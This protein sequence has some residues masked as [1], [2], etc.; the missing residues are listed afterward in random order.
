MAINIFKWLV[1]KNADD[2]II[3]SCKNLDEAYTDYYLR[4]LAF[5]VCVNIYAKALTL[6]E[7]ETLRNGKRIKDKEYYMLNIEPNINQ[8]KSEFLQDIVKS[9]FAKNEA[10]C[11]STKHRDGH[12]MLVCADS[13]QNSPRYPAKMN[14][15]SGVTVGE[16]Q[17]DKTF[18]ENEVLHF[19]LNNSNID[20]LIN[21][22]SASYNKLIQAAE[23]AYSWSNGK[24][25]VAEIEQTDSAKTASGKSYAEVFM[26][27]AEKQIAPWMKSANGVLPQFKGWKYVFPNVGESKVSSSDIKALYDDVF[28][29]TAMAFGIPAPLV[30]GKVADSKDSF[31]RWLTTGIDPLCRQIEEEIIRKRYGFDL[32]QNGTTIHI[33]TNTIKHF[34]LFENANNIEKLISSGTHSIND[35]LEAMGSSAINEDYANIHW[36]TKNIDTAE[37]VSRSIDNA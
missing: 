21:M 34:D 28:E 25:L 29:Y 7:F 16:V 14:E 13:W 2:P 10:L 9:L 1:G 18:R 33:N 23:T 17:Y 36:M 15:Y 3:E 11:I 8:N 35:V 6:C 26:E 19:R 22:L 32:W 24:H 37:N 5:D 27:M 12:E 31:D 4:K 20:G 30:T